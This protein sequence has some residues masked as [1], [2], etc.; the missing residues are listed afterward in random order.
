MLPHSRAAIQ[1]FRRRRLNRRRDRQ[2]RIAD[3]LQPRER[4]RDQLPLATHRHPGEFDLRQTHGLRQTAKAED[5]PVLDVHHA[6][7]VDAGSRPELV[8]G[9]HLVGDNRDAALGAERRQPLQLLPCDK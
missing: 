6:A 9:K 4:I 7:G 3:Q 2:V 8:V 5:Q 1:Q